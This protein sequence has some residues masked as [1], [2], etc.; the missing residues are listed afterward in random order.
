[1]A[2]GGAFFIM[3]PLAGKPLWCISAAWLVGMMLVGYVLMPSDGDMSEHM[4]LV[5]YSDV[6]NTIAPLVSPTPC[7]PALVDR[8]DETV[9][10]SMLSATVRGSFISH[11]HSF[12]IQQDKAGHL[13]R[14]PTLDGKSVH[15]NRQAGS[16]EDRPLYETGILHD[17]APQPSVAGFITDIDRCNSRSAVDSG[18]VRGS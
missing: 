14:Q 6:D 13:Y 9:V 4:A 18:G 16:H 15:D 3:M 17:T 5:P 8:V 1:M 2:M 12:A 11:G 10:H 7:W